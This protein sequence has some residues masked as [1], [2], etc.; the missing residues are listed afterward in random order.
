M[1]LDC[2]AYRINVK[3]FKILLDSKTEEERLEYIGALAISSQVPII[4]VACYVGELYGFTD[5]LKRM[6]AKWA[7]F[8]GVDEI[9]NAT[10]FT[11]QEAV[12]DT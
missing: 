8:Y 10:G 4:V 3:S 11:L 6:I 1:R 5:S 2:D 9:A 12:Y 7:A